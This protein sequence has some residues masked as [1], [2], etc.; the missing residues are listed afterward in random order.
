MQQPVRQSGPGSQ[1][2]SMRGQGRV[3]HCLPLQRIRNWQAIQGAAIWL[4]F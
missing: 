4:K 2:K 1:S 3:R